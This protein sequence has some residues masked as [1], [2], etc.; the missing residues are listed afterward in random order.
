[1]L[2][3]TIVPLYIHT[4]TLLFSFF[5]FP[6]FY[7]LNH[8]GIEDIMSLYPKMHPCVFSKNKDSHITMI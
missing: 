2:T 8:F 1:M 5:F 4:H 7:F 3:F 6:H